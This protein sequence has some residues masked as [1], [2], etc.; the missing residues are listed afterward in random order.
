MGEIA[1]AYIRNHRLRWTQKERAMLRRLL[2]ERTPLYVMALRM[3]RS[4]RAI[5][6]RIAESK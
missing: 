5:K 4:K 3:G 2:A 6:E 1:V